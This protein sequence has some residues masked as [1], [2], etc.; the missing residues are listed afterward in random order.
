ME[1]LIQNAY[2]ITF[3]KEYG[4]IP[5]GYLYIKDGKILE[6]GH[7][8]YGKDT[9]RMKI[10]DAGQKVVMP[11]LVNAH[12]HCY[13]TFARG[14]SL[15]DTPPS[16]F[17]EILDKLW[18]RLDKKLT[19]ED[20]Y[21]STLIPVMEG[22]RSGVTTFIDHHASP[23]CVPGCLDE[24]EK[25]FRDAGMRGILCYEVSDRDGKEIARQGLEE[26]I[27]FIKKGQK[28][29][30]SLLRG[31]FG[32][33]ASFTV[34]DETMRKAVEEAKK[35]GVGLHLHV[36][37]DHADQTLTLQNTKKRVV[38]RLWD[39]GALGPKSIAAHAVWVDEEEKDLLAQSKTWTIHNPRSNMNN[40][41]GA[42][43]FLGIFNRG[44]QV[45]L[46]TDGMSASIWPDLRTAAI[47]HKH[48]K[49][50]PRVV[51]SEL[52]ALLE[53]NYRL[54]NEFL[55]IQVGRL[56][57]G[58]ASDVVIYNYFAPTPLTQD[59]FLGH[60]LFGFA[61]AQADTVLIHD[62]VI[63]EKGQFAFLDEKEIARKSREQAVRFWKRFAG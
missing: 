9:S 15:G 7:G 5:E 33:H 45:C 44:T 62:K 38:K 40:A 16:C 23:N 4:V 50:N 51:W 21:Y 58:A 56:E 14:M 31:T 2:L 12:M 43:D 35:L 22:I 28:S 26:N 3:T 30:D 10:I 57:P 54:A 37:E 11:G 39:V 60:F 29:Q 63:L 46:G 20:L 1:I 8:A 19:T 53:N 18:W 61:H 27:R 49:R 36:A 6:L 32:L 41:V 24:L 25:A 17:V 48:E 59:N 47:I 42:M 34:Y 55:P 52:F 13:S